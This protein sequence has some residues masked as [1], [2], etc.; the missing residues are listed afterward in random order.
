MSNWQYKYEH[1]CGIIF[2]FFEGGRLLGLVRYRYGT[3]PLRYDVYRSW[4]G[5]YRYRTVGI[6]IVIGYRLS[7]SYKKSYTVHG[8]TPAL[9][10]KYLRK[11]VRSRKA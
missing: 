5:R 6:E 8:L 2:L 4:Y 1:G 3:V 7:V 9:A 11:E 10:L